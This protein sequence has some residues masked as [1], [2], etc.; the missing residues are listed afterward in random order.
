MKSYSLSHLPDSVLLRDLAA[1]ASQDR[2]TTAKLIAYIAEV[3]VRR[4]FVEAGHPSMFAYCVDVLHLSEDATAKRIQAARVARRFPVLFAALDDGR[5]HL[6]AISLLAPH[7]TP[8]NVNE[9]I[10]AAT[11]R[12]KSE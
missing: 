6:T 1:M 10:E 4:L 3:D 7:F 11:H 5:L 12:K 8:E 2:I 9:L